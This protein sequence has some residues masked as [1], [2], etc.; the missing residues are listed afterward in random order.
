MTTAPEK[1]EAAKGGVQF[2]DSFIAT[3]PGSAYV[4]PPA[5]HHGERPRLNR[6][7]NHEC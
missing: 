3:L 2:L 6:S 5:W 4:E 1:T 7:E